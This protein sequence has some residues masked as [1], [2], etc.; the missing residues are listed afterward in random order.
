MNYIDIVIILL[1]LLFIAIGVWRGFISD[2]LTLLG[3]VISTAAAFLLYVFLGQKIYAWLQNL[4]DGSQVPQG[5]ANL[6]SF[7][8]IFLVLQICLLLLINFIDKKIYQ[9]WRDSK[10]FRTLNTI[11]GSIP[12]FLNGAII[13]S[14]LLLILVI[15]PANPRFKSHLS[16]SRLAIFFLDRVAV[17]NDKLEDVFRPAA[18]ET[19]AK[20]RNLVGSVSPENTS[21]LT[22][23]KNLKLVTDYESEKRMV[24][25]INA[26]RVRR[27]LNPLV[28]DPT[29]TEI[30][31]SHSQ[32][33]FEL[34]YFDHKSPISGSPFD[35][36]KAAGIH[37]QAAGE[38][39]AYASNVDVAHY[40]LMD[41]PSHRDNIL[42]PNFEKI[43]IGVILAESWGE[44]FCQ[45]FIK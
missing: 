39:I 45:E 24:D 41:S 21:Q 19:K 32:E 5:I 29:L 34:S 15:V 14:L 36:M 42:E 16:D 35:R 33:M 9:R 25:L 23:P 6:I 4:P 40:G 43:G 28:V 38:N 8:A 1:F 7:L 31:R 26:E 18:D 20:I 27:G 17:L 37:Y 22:F 11:L 12:G 3:F 13:I 44:M 30:A 2:F 10:W